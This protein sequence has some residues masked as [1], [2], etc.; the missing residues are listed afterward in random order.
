[1][2][3]PEP[4]GPTLGAFYTD[5]GLRVVAELV[6]AHDPLRAAFLALLLYAAEDGA[7]GALLA[8][9]EHVR[10]VEGRPGDPHVGEL[11][12]HDVIPATST[13]TTDPTRYTPR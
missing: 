9:V 1:V 10:A 13:Y 4:D 2:P 12:R 8:H 7:S 3:A 5:A 6:G 11:R